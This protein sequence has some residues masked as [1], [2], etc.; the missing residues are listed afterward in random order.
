MKRVILLS[1][2]FFLLVCLVGFACKQ[3]NA[4]Q[5]ALQKTSASG[6]FEPVAVIELFTSQGCS[7]CPPADHLL[8]QT[9]NEAKKDGTKIYALS[10]HV[11]YWNRLGWADPFSTKEYSQR[12]SDYAAQLNLTSVY[13]P[14]M[15][16]NGSREFVGSDAG[17]LKSALSEALGTKNPAAFKTFTAS[18]QPGQ[19]PEINYSLEG[20]YSNCKINI[21]LVSLSE[22]TSVKRGENSGLTLT[23]ENIVRQFVSTDA[24]ANGTVHFKN[25]PLP[26]EG[27]T[28]VIAYLQEKNDLKIIAA[29][30]ASMP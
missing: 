21:A 5:P 23:N 15:I 16:V 9:I 22:T 18:M 4:K 17:S 3:G 30:K 27:N 6:S 20:N 7:S 11:D 13:T 25:T 8:T 28:A 29:A 24:S 19:A 2:S 1:A 12:Q 26:S 14:Q 10:F